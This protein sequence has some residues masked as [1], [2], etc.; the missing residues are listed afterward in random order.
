M[1]HSQPQETTPLHRTQCHHCHAGIPMAFVIVFSFS[2]PFLPVPLDNLEN[3]N[4]YRVR[5]FCTATSSSKSP[6]EQSTGSAMQWAIMTLVEPWS[7]TS[8]MHPCTKG[9]AT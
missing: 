9:C 1:R 2:F 4:K 5:K 3:S 8:S 7:V 6:G